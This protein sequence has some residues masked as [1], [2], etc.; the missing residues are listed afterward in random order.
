MILSAIY[1]FIN[2]KKWTIQIYDTNTIIST[3][4]EMSDFACQSFSVC[5]PTWAVIEVPWILRL[6]FL[7]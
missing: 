3:R 2:R 5:G 6:E 7:E 4:L 1:F